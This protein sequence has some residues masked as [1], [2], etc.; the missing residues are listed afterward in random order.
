[1]V[2]FCKTFSALVLFAWTTYCILYTSCVIKFCSCDSKVIFYRLFI[3]VIW[4]QSAKTDLRV[5]IFKILLLAQNSFLG[6]VDDAQLESIGEKWEY[7]P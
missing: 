3:C 5:K 2:V 1:M 7:R 6:L 4:A